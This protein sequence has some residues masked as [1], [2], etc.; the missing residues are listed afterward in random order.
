LNITNP[1][2]TRYDETTYATGVAVVALFS[3]RKGTVIK[4]TGAESDGHEWI[5]PLVKWDDGEI[6][7]VGN[8]VLYLSDSEAR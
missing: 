3:G 4:V 5:M 7:F 6:S 2:L 8:D 1:L